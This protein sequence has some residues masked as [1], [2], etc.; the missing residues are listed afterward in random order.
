MSSTGPK[1]RLVLLLGIG[2][3]VGLV[4]IL[5][6]PPQ[7]DL[8]RSED[9]QPPGRWHLQ[10][11]RLADSAGDE[12]L[13]R[14]LSLPY[15]SGSREATSIEGVTRHDPTRVSPGVNLYVS[16]HGPEVVLM[17]MLGKPL[18]RWRYAFEKAF[19]DTPPTLDT[20]YIRRAHLYPDGE[21]L[22]LYQGGG[23]IKMDR[24]SQLIW[25]SPLPYYNHLF[26]TP[27]G[28]IL[29][30][31]KTA[32]MIPELRAD[33]AVLEDSIVR[34]DSA[35]RVESRLS[36]LESF[37]ASP[38]A[39]TI[40]PLPEHADIFH[41][42]TVI[43]ISRDLADSSELFVAGLLVVSLREIDTVALIDPAA[44]SVSA[45]WRGPW[46]A[47]HQPLPLS[48]G[49]FLVFDNK[50]GKSG[51]RVIEYDPVEQR[52]AEVFPADT[53]ETLDS[54]E[55]GS[56]QR[57]ANGNTLI[58]ESEM[59]RALEITPQGDVVWEFSTPHRAGEK[60]QL[61]ATL[62]EVI[63]YPSEELTFVERAG[64]D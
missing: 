47:Q 23:M 42:N 27:G 13:A 44:G 7:D 54:P 20:A 4:T 35:G 18:H 39:D 52:I 32:R 14:V 34:L 40:H 21:L 61:V 29:S 3:L 16:G 28:Q 51:S 12:E 43:P 11:S 58:T 2:L 22:A 24:K 17:D 41:T 6:R 50:G 55:A 45:A 36:L 62:F 59:G 37:A 49:R 26:V 15:V 56:V 38:F 64:E 25:A 33:S 31:A 9:I 30:I 63:R 10:S 5:W 48:S 8:L 57:L 46:R 53:S 1:V 60:R 19:P